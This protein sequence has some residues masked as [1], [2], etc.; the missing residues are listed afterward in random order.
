MDFVK[1]AYDYLGNEL[2]GISDALVPI[3]SWY[4][5]IVLFAFIYITIYALAMRKVRKEL[6]KRKVILAELAQYKELNQVKGETKEKVSDED[7]M[8]MIIQRKQPI[9]SDEYYD[10][11]WE[12]VRRQKPQPFIALL[13]LT[14]QV[15]IAAVFFAFFAQVDVLPKPILYYVVGVILLGFVF[16]KKKK[17]IL[18]LC[19]FGLVSYIYWK[20][21]AAAIIFAMMISCYR[22]VND[23]IMK[24][25]L[26]DS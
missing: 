10:G 23:I 13:A 24:K 2:L 17:W 4:G 16:I 26:S 7:Y 12:I 22:I 14:F 15:F 19:I 11:M 21:T 25:R 8:K 18:R 20:L 6:S 3:I 1:L 5:V 9:F